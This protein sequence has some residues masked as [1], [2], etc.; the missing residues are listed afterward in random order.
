MRV[1]ALG[2]PPLTQR[3]GQLRM[4]APGRPGAPV[5]YRDP[6]LVR[7]PTRDQ[8]LARQIGWIGHARIQT[9]TEDSNRSVIKRKHRHATFAH[10]QLRSTR[11]HH[12]P[13]IR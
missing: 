8:L 7:L 5:S 2:C 11:I 1:L 9:G 10:P 12:D 13:R 3:R 6:D 4:P